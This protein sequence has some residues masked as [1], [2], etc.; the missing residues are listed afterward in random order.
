MSSA[1]TLA[2]VVPTSTS[3]S[4]QTSA[5]QLLSIERIKPHN[6]AREHRSANLLDEDNWLNWH[7]DIELA[8]CVCD[9]QGYITGDLKCPNDKID[10]VGASNWEYNDN[11]TKKVICDHLSGGQK[12]HI[13]N[14]NT[15]HTMWANLEAIYQS[16]RYQTKNQLMYEL[17]DIKI[18]EGDDVP[19]RLAQIMKLWN[20]IKI[21]CHEQK[22]KQDIKEQIVYLLPC[23]WDN[24]TWPY[25]TQANKMTIS[26]YG[27]IG[28][29]NEEFRHH[30]QHK[31]E[32]A[33]ETANPYT[34]VSKA[35]LTKRI[36][37]YTSS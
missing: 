36:G 15:V 1:Q 28:E 2:P 14:C 4:T 7:M 19:E 29:C 24:F 32:Q 30:Q 20:R 3:T 6:Y 23:S 13:D 27:L 8:F 26:I 22:S 18:K 34:S 10:P 31:K 33:Q 9:L 21:V 5:I 16:H 12:F 25:L 17:N 37:G 11:Y 35:P